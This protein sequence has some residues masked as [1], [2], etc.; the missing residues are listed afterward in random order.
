MNEN[1]KKITVGQIKILILCF[2]LAGLPL[3]EIWAQPIPIGS[4]KEMQF[5]LL[6]LLSDST[7]TT[8]FLNRPVWDSSYQEVFNPSNTRSGRWWGQPW[9]P[10]EISFS[11]FN[12][13]LN[14]GAYDAVFKNTYNS[15]LPHG[16]NNGAA[17]YGRGFTTE[18]KAGFYINSKYFTLTFRPQFF[19]SQ[20]KDFKPPRFVPK[21]GNGVIRYVAGGRLPEYRLA[22]RIDLPW[23]FG[24]DSFG[25]FDLGL[26]SVRLHYKKLEAGISKG[27]LRWGPGVRYA[28]AMSNNAPGL[29]HIFF[30]TRSP[31]KLPFNIG[32]IEFRWILGSPKDSPYF[33]LYDL[34]KYLH[35]Y[36]R[37]FPDLKY[38]KSEKILSETRFLNGINFVYT[39]SFLPNLSLGIIRVIQQYVPDGGLSFAKDILDVFQPFPKPKG[40]QLS[41]GFSSAEH[42]INKYPISSY[43]FRWVLPGADAEFYG[44]YFK[45]Q[46]N[47]NVR[48]LLME[49]QNGRAY[50]IGLQKLI[51]F[52]G[53][54]DFLK[55]NAEINQTS[56]SWIDELR[57]Q[58]NIYTSTVIRQGYTNEGQLMGGGS[59]FGPDLQSQFVG[60]DAYFDRGMAGIFFQRQVIKNTYYYEYHDRYFPQG[61]FKDQIHH[62][63]NLNAGLH[64]MYKIGPVLLEGKFLFNRHFNYGGYAP[65]RHGS[66]DTPVF[67]IDNYQGQL[68]IHYLF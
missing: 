14:T 7:V 60:V 17:W 43:Y 39:P 51:E 46:H 3:T 25:K 41:Y 8:S 32:K 48:D 23:R 29:K 53:P 45:G 65:V 40:D 1:A 63:V 2:C 33:D 31:I 21:D 49:P 50:T 13:K 12:Y 28:L 68:S 16:F 57:P 30:G 47:R 24:P 22:N 15:A 5:R 62:R 10:K 35:F 19:Y 67:I 11:I 64:A 6:Q 61:G 27:N 20:N 52:T 9:E 38:P 56:S 55:I 42:F 54:L 58:K 18:L 44:E 26:T 66:Y 59:Q 4:A 36:N 37:L 34:N